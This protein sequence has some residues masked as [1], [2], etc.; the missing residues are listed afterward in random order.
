MISYVINNN[1]IL[2]SEFKNTMSSDEYKVARNRIAY[3]RHTFIA[4]HLRTFRICT[5]D[6]YRR[7]LPGRQDKSGGELNYFVDIKNNNF[8]YLLWK[9]LPGRQEKSGGELNYFV[10]IKN[11]DFNYL[12]WRILPGRQEKSGEELNYFVD[13]KNNNFNYLLWK[14]LPGRQEKSGG[15][16]NYFVDV[17]TY[18]EP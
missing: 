7:I 4:I 3:H 14:I 13:I 16:L 1:M 11:N 8:N 17:K 18:S 9:G 2:N 15:E 10:D 6:S 5:C 12:L